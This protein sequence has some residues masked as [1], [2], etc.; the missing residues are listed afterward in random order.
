MFHLPTYKFYFPFDC[1]FADQFALGA[2]FLPKLKMT[3]LWEELKKIVRQL[4]GLQN[5]FGYKSTVANQIFLFYCFCGKIYFTDKIHPG[6]KYLWYILVLS[7][8]LISYALTLVYF[9]YDDEHDVMMMLSAANVVS[10]SNVAVFGFPLISY[11]C[12]DHIEAIIDQVDDIFA[13]EENPTGDSHS[14]VKQLRVL[15]DVKNVFWS[16]LG[17]FGVCCVV[18]LFICFFDVVLFFKEEKVKNDYYYYMSPIP[19]MRK[20]GSFKLFFIFNGVSTFVFGMFLVKLISVFSVVL[21]WNTVCR[22]ELICLRDEFHKKSR[23]LSECMEKGAWTGGTLKKWNRDFNAVIVRGV[24]KFQETVFLINYLKTFIEVIG[25]F[26]TPL[27]FFYGVAVLYICLSEDIFFVLKLKY[28]AGT[29]G[30][31]F[32]AFIFY[33]TGQK[34][35]DAIFEVSVA[36]YSTPWYWSVN[37]RRNVHFLLYQTQNVQ[38]FSILKVYGLLLKNFSRYAN[39]VMTST[40]LLRKLTRE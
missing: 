5:I 21:Y 26:V 17:F 15:A 16:L 25:S 36:V 39:G 35:D 34:L 19:P 10:T 7:E 37:V 8:L 33:W 4:R 3:L 32:S 18:Y 13:S 30:T 11:I 14:G 31:T 6:V 28:V 38:N 9:L 40:N 12:G 23:S 22:N 1:R 20:H 29:L 24:V 2:D 27:A